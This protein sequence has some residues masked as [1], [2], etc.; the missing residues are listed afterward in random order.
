M[1]VW[2]GGG[3]QQG[4]GLYLVPGFSDF[5]ASVPPSWARAS[6]V[7]GMVISAD[8]VAGLGSGASTL[9][10]PSGDREEETWVGS[11][12]GGSLDRER[13]D[14]SDPRCVPG[15]SPPPT[16]PGARTHVYFRVKH[17]EMKPCSSCRSSC[18][19]GWGR[20]V[21]GG[22]KGPALPLAHSQPS[23]TRWPERLPGED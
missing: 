18:L 21:R 2:A 17:R 20:E 19:P 15:P 16:P 9:S 13:Q 23:P 14:R 7:T 11:T 4:E 3:E 1:R 8:W 10:V 5:P 22:L 12:P 6:K